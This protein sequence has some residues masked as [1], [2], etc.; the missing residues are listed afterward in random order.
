MPSWLSSGETACPI[1]QPCPDFWQPSTRTRWKP[2]AHVFKRMGLRA[3]PFLPLVACSTGQARGG[4][5]STW[6][7]PDKRLVNEH[8]RKRTR[9][10]LP[11]AGSRLC[12]H[13]A[14]PGFDL[15]VASCLI[16]LLM[17]LPAG[18][19]RLTASLLSVALTCYVL[20]DSMNLYG[21]LHHA[22]W[23]LGWFS[24]GWTLGMFLMALAAQ[25]MRW[26]LVPR[27]PVP[28]TTREPSSPEAMAMWR[29]LIPYALF[30]AVLAL[31][32]YVWRTGQD[33]PLAIGA[34][35]CSVLLLVLIFLKQFL[36][37]GEIRWLNRGLEHAQQLLQEKN[38][39]L[40]TLATTDPLT[41]LPNHRALLGSLESE[42]A[43]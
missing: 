5:S 32:I 36:V 14:Y 20:A 17:H 18:P 37:M 28:S 15:L 16:L 35:A 7:E 6:M 21:A 11:I 2:C 43:R 1:A 13:L 3:L 33:S 30:P 27:A 24:L 38:A 40:E 4:W 41:E 31:D 26:L 23:M 39:R 34:Y 29:A 22:G 9:C 19:L 8:C 10:P 25:T 12:A 42:V